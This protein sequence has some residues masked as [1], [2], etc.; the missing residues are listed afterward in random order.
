LTIKID[1][2]FK[3]LLAP[4][5][6]EEYNQ[7]Q[8]NIEA[9]GCREPLVIWKGEDILVDGHN[10]LEI[11]NELGVTFKTRE[12][13]FPSREAAFNWIIAQQLGRRNLKPE[14]VAYLRGK[15]Y[16]GEKKTV[17]GDR[18]S[19]AENQH[20][21]TCERLAEEY[22]VGKSTIQENG[23]FSEAV[24]AI[25]TAL[26]EETKQAILSGEIKRP[27]KII[28]EA[29][30]MAETQP[31]RARKILETAKPQPVKDTSDD[32]K[33]K[34]LVR[35]KND[36]RLNAK[37]GAF[38]YPNGSYALAVVVVEGYGVDYAT[39]LRSS[40]STLIGRKKKGIEE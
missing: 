3:S 20:M 4:L 35:I 37:V 31:E 18:K 1:P 21:K 36:I 10:R 32:S 30:E 19:G 34:S 2:E 26:G 33:P 16:R 24:D 7:L 27:R 5:S 13:P 8:A 15:R 11:C 40:L 6:P 23:K 38:G 39:K 9:D 22:G 28:Q 14:Q 17:G 29:A 25:A 12:Q